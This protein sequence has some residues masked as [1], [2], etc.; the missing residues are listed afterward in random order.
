MET[1][2]NIN[3]VIETDDIKIEDFPDKLF[4]Y[5]PLGCHEDGSM[6]DDQKYHLS[7][8]RLVEAITNQECFLASFTTT[9]PAILAIFI[10]L[11]GM[12]DCV[13]FFKKP[14]GFVTSFP[15]ILLVTEEVR[16]FLSS[17][18][19]MSIIY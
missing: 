11:N 5:K 16:L 1:I 7:M 10:S 13:F 2:C 17:D 4:P 3:K 15:W 9:I 14:D 18:V 19:I 6:K 12:E 8:T